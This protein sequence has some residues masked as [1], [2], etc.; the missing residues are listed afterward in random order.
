[1]FRDDAYT[2]YANGD[3]IGSAEDW[4]S[5]EVYSIPQLDPDVNVVA[6]DGANTLANSPGWLAGGI[7]IAYSDGSSERYLTDGS[8]KTITSA[9]PAGFEQVTTDDSSWV[10]STGLGAMHSGV[11]VPRA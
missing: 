10:N 7:L 6:V 2:L 4:T 1:M 5:M 9:P 11:T 3:N 8:W